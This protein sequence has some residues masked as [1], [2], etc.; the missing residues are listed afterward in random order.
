MN[1]DLLIKLLKCHSTPGDEDEVAAC[2]TR[3][4]QR[5]QWKITHH[6]P[7]GISARSAHF[8]S[9]KSTVLV[10]AH[11]D[12]PGYIVDSIDNDR[13]SI[14]KLGGPALDG[15]SQKAIV[16]TKNGKF[17]IEIQKSKSTDCLRETY[18]FKSEIDVEY[19]DR[20]CFDSKPL[21]TNDG[22]ITSPFLDNRIGCFV[23]G[24]LAENKKY[25][26]NLP[27]NLVL[28]TTS[29]EEIGSR[30]A[31]VLAHA[32]KPDYVICLDAT[33]ENKSQNVE[34]GGGPVLTISDASV[35]LSCQNRDDIIN[36]FRINNIPLQTEVYNYS[37]TDAKAFPQV[38]LHCLVIPL[39]I[40]STGNHSSLERVSINDIETLVNGVQILIDDFENNTLVP[41]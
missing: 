35:I 41:D 34:I 11:M 25:K 6:G 26:Q 23:L 14:V 28:G 37:G 12:S 39:L 30:G 3:F 31:T 33:Y 32:I 9:T 1:L 8:D 29:C 38:G 18:Y 2:M 20:V 4:W 13:K 16:K 36:L 7:Y 19:G 17:P 10:C 40:A 24:L 27:F 21:I 5:N 15:E 22:M